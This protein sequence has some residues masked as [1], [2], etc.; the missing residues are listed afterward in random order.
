MLPQHTLMAFEPSTVELSKFQ[1]AF[2]PSTMMPSKL[3]MAFEPSTMALGMYMGEKL[4]STTFV[5]STCER[6]RRYLRRSVC[7]RTKRW[8]MHNKDTIVDITLD[9]LAEP[10]LITSGHSVWGACLYMLL[11]VMIIIRP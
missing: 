2:K 6:Q 5:L 4:F 3:Q 9:E 11:L 7:A 8:I 1:M 10:L